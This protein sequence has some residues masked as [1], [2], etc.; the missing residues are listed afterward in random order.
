MFT[1]KDYYVENQVRQDQ[2]KAV[3]HQRL[4]KSMRMEKDSP[5]RKVVSQ[6]LG[7]IGTRLVIWGDILIGRCEEMTLTSSQRSPQSNV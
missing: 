2:R 5:A 3:D 6:Q 1:W 7:I 4:L